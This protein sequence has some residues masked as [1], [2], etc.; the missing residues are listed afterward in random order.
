ME[1]M[2]DLIATEA[3]KFEDGSLQVN[4]TT[5]DGTPTWI[6]IHYGAEIEPRQFENPEE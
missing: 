1:R 3:I 4:G 6:L 2:K 5:L